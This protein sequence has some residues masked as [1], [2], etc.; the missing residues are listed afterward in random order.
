MPEVEA[1]VK[2]IQI[3]LKR[4]ETLELQLQEERTLT[5]L[6]SNNCDLIAEQLQQTNAALMNAC[7]FIEEHMGTCP[8]D[9]LGLNQNDYG[10][11]KC[12]NKLP[13]CWAKYFMGKGESNG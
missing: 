13:E 12:D 1:E 8:V 3:A 11:E 10:C 4:I 5:R 2:F 7:G 9:L 6:H